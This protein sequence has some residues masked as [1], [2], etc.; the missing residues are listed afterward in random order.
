MAA[1]KGQGA[2]LEGLQFLDFPVQILFQS[3]HFPDGLQIKLSG[4]SQLEG[5][6]VPLKKR[7]A[8]PGLDLA[9]GNA[10]R[11]LGDEQFFRRPGETAFL[12]DGVDVFVGCFHEKILSTI[13]EINRNIYGINWIIYRKNDIVNI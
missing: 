10:E 4:R 6:A 2:G 1:P 12:V 7:H 13:K 11:R 8:D 9:Q 3:V 5:T